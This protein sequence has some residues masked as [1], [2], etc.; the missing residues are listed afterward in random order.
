MVPHAFR[1]AARGVLRF[2][3]RTLWIRTFLIFPSWSA[4]CSRIRTVNL[5]D[6][7]PVRTL[8][9]PWRMTVLIRMQMKRRVLEGDDLVEISPSAA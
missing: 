2:V 1:A 8:L 6:W 7:T 3:A 4:R 5:L 9:L